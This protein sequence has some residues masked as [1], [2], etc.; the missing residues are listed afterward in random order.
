MPGIEGRDDDHDNPDCCDDTCFGGSE[1][2]GQNAT[3]QN[4]RDHQWECGIACRKRNH[5][6]RSAGPLE[7]DWSKEIAIDHQPESDH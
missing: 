6:E 2:A 5:P 7:S 4:D 3:K 1:P